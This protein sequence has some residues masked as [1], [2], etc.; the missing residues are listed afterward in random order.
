MKSWFARSMS[1]FA[2]L[3]A[4]ATFMLTEVQAKRLG[5]GESVGRQQSGAMQRQATPPSQ[6]QAATAPRQ[7]PAATPQ[8]QRNRW[9]GPLAGL[10]AGLGLAALASYLGF[11]EELASF[12]LIAL[13]AIVALV[14]VRMIMAR[15]AAARQPMQPAWAG[16][17][18]GSGQ[19]S[20]APWPQQAATPAPQNSASSGTSLFSPL[21]SD[22]Q[23]VGGSAA[24]GMAPAGM[25]DA[26]ASTGLR[27]PANFDI[28]GFV[29][30]AKVQFIRLQAAFDAG[31][32]NDLREFTTPEMFAELQMQIRERGDKPNVTEVV[33]L[34]AEFLGVDSSDVEHL[35]SIRF[36][37]VIREDVGA[38]AESFDEI[39]NLSKPSIGAG[40]WTL[41]GI[42][43]NQ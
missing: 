8:P 43:Q 29:R 9:L 14:V 26:P 42:Q 17:A 28:S 21:S 1:V 2:A 30:N 23:G 18:A 32:L 22:Q 40:G 19:P 13:L 16:A 6:Q 20:A 25:A 15:R 5:S 33:S 39:W 31:N 11:G 41:A 34:E 4:S 35:A 3:V 10:A 37:G 36:Y 38:N 12:M 27:I 7:A 24:G